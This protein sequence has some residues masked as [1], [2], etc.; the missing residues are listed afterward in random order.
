MDRDIPKVPE[1]IKIPQEDQEKEF[2]WEVT[3]K[4]VTNGYIL[5]RK[6]GLKGE[7][8][9]QIE[10][11]VFEDIEETEDMLETTK[12]MFY[13]ILEHFGIYYSKHEDKNLVVK[14]EN[15]EKE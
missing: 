1:N 13:G 3:V 2:V 6:S 14:V 4:K 5:I 9:L 7:E 11:E 8:L 10:T 12:N 15:V